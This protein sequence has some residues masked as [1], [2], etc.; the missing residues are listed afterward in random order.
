MFPAYIAS[1]QGN[2]GD[3]E[4]LICYDDYSIG[5]IVA[6]NITAVDGK[7]PQFPSGTAFEFL[8]DNQA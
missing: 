1:F 8:I 4:T 7:P 6:N 5:I 2:R 3:I